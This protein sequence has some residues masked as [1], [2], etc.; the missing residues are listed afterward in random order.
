MR[1]RKPDPL[2]I[3]TTTYLLSSP[4]NARRL[5][6]SIAEMHNGIRANTDASSFNFLPLSQLRPPAPHL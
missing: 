6:R 4:A 1:K 5:L 3:D 2:E